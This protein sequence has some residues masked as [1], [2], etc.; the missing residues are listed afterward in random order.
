MDRQRYREVAWYSSTQDKC[1]GNRQ[2]NIVSELDMEEGT[3]LPTNV[4]D[5]VSVAL[6]ADTRTQKCKETA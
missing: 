4:E 1:E 5:L 2:V 3:D 6:K